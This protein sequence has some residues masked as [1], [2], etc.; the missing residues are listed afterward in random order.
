MSSCGR[1]INVGRVFLFQFQ[2]IT[3]F[4]LISC[5]FKAGFTTLIKTEPKSE[6]KSETDA[7]SYNVSA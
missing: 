6:S 2:N 3:K 5:G 1:L 4:S 7:G